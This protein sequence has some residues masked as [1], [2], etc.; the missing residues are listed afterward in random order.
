MKGIVSGVARVLLALGA[1]AGSEVLHGQSGHEED[2]LK[3][4]ERIFEGMRAADG[5]V[6]R[7]VFAEGAR[8]ALLDESGA[9]PR[10]TFQSMEGW[11]TAVAASEGRWDERIYDA[12]VQ[13]DGAMASAWTPYTFY[14]DGVVRHCGVNSIELLRGADGWKVTQISDTRRTEGCPDPRSGR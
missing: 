9:M 5:E 8:F 12:V 4:V 3:A 14:L 1:L 6:A 10:I 11:L 13:V 7:G 2:V